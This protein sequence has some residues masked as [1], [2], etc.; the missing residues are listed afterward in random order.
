MPFRCF[1]RVIF[2]H[3]IFLQNGLTPLHIACHY[4]QSEVAIQLLN[5]GANIE[6]HAKVGIFFNLFYVFK[7]KNT[8]WKAEE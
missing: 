2:I 5:A 7:E 3:H 6:A 1:N 4:D 8:T